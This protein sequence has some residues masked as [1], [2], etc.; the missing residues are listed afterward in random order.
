MTGAVDLRDWRFRR[1]VER[2]HRLG[3]RVLHEFLAELGAARMCR[4]EIEILA[5][6]YARL[7]PAILDALGIER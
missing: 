2:L 7:D 1:D 5:R 3:P 4:T 6:R